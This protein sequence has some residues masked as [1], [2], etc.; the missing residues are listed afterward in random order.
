MVQ[1][2]QKTVWRFLRKLIIVL[3]YD[4]TVPLL[5]IVHT[6]NYNLKDTCT[7]VLIAALFTVAQA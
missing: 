5:S 6:Q 1:P 3:I 7:P 2:P 4:P